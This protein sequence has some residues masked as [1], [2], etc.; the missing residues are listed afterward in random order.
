MSIGAIILISAFGL[1]VGILVTAFTVR[2][3]RYLRT[4]RLEQQQRAEALEQQHRT[5]VP[6]PPLPPPALFPVPTPPP[7]AP[8]PSKQ[9]RAPAPPRPTGPLPIPKVPGLDGQRR[10]YVEWCGKRISDAERVVAARREQAERALSDAT[11]EL[12]RTGQLL[13]DA[14]RRVAWLE[15]LRRR[16]TDAAGADFDALAALP[17]VARAEPAAYGWCV[18]TTGIRVT[19][20]EHRVDLGKYEIHLGL[21][22]RC[23]VFNQSCRP[24]VGGTTWDHPWVRNGEP[25]FPPATCVRVIRAIATSAYA[26]AITAIVEFLAGDDA[27]RGLVPL[28]HWPRIAPEKEARDGLRRIVA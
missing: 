15:E 22:G 16:R 2:M 14:E 24:I 20:G 4:Q 10:L 5:T 12:F 18:V 3:V 9:R 11:S 6:L 28:T 25:V 17:T 23:R 13:A 21:T 1:G 19:D 8:T 26:E 7:P 27:A